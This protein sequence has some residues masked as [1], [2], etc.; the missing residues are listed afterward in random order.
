[1]GGVGLAPVVGLYFWFRA[2]ATHR[3]AAGPVIARTAIPELSAPPAVDLTGADP[4]IAAAVEK[5]RAEV[6]QSPHSGAAWGYLGMVLFAHRFHAEA[7]VCLGQAERLDLREIRWPYYQGQMLVQENLDM[8]IAKLQQAVEVGSHAPDAPRLLL[9]DLLAV[10]GR[11]DEAA[12]Q[13]R[14]V[15][16]AEPGNARAHLGLGRLA[17]ERNDLPEALVQLDASCLADLRTR[18]AAGTLIAGIHRHQGE[19]AAADQELKRVAALPPDA[20]WPDPLSD[21]VNQLQTGRKANCDR[22]RQLYDR[23]YAKEAISLLR[24]TVRDYPRSDVAWLML[25]QALLGQDDF[26]GAEQAL[27]AAVREAPDS[28]ENLQYLGLALVGRHDDPAA[29]ACFRKATELRPQNAQANILLG[30]SLMRQ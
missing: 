7:M 24:R 27:R 23:G 10:R 1:L 30:Q 18:K 25:G 4:A 11:R 28:D 13:Y 12:D 20:P 15:L 17:Y 2:R 3:G 16:A 14:V 6:S 26:E 29:A 21:E 5:A 22:A 19:S 9:A 8:A